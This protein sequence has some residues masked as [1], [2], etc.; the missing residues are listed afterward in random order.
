MW[1]EWRKWA[2]RGFRPFYISGEVRGSVESG[3]STTTGR[4]REARDV[5]LDR[6]V[7]LPGSTGPRRVFHREWVPGTQSPDPFHTPTL[8]LFTYPSGSY[9]VQ[10]EAEAQYFL[11]VVPGVKES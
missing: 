4:E 7:C 10:G 8:S 3:G 5:D 9:M 2:E 1:Q 11:N 6:G